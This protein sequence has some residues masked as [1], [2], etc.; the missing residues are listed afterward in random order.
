MLVVQ[1]CLT[2][3]NPV[4]CSP[5]GSS[6]HGTLQSRILEQ[7]ALLFSSESS[8]SRDWTWSPTLQADS[9]LPE[10]PGNP[11]LSTSLSLCSGLPLYLKYSLSLSLSLGNDF[12]FTHQGIFL[13]YSIFKSYPFMSTLINGKR[14]IFSWY[15]SDSYF[16]NEC[17]YSFPFCFLPY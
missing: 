1:S 10:P 5:P 2:F 13:D 17:R 7:V 11:I 8:L 15:A 4:D 6:V 12:I 16:I 3:C 9:L 14:T